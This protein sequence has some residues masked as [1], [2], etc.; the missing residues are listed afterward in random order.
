MGGDLMAITTEAA[1]K[2]QLAIPE[3]RQIFDYWLSRSKQDRLPSRCDINPCDFPRLLPLI[4]L[5][6]VDLVHKRF[7]VR[8][9]GTQ[10]REHYGRDITGIYLDQVDYGSKTDYW[11]SAFHRV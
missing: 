5:I 2:A 4:S 6:D 1:F 11:L 10:L 8:L 3:Q 9:A 7:R